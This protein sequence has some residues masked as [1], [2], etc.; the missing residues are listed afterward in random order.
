MAK[1]SVV[2]DCDGCKEAIEN[3]INGLICKTKDPKD[4]ASKIATILDD[5]NLANYMGQN[6]RKMVLSH[7]NQPLITAKYIK[8]YKELAGV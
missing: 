7:Y 5:E 2:S 3:G 6:G 8:F 1:P 4:L